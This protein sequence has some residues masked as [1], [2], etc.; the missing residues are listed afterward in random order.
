[1]IT[2][3]WPRLLVV[4]QPVTPTQAGEILLRTDDWW[5]SGNDQA[6]VNDLE[7]TLADYGRPREPDRRDVDGFQEF[8]EFYRLHD[9]WKASLGVLTLHYLQNS[10]IISTW[11]GGPHGWCDWDGT[12]GCSTYNIGKWPSDDEVAEDWQVIAET[13]PFLDLTAHLVDDEG[14]G[15]V[16]GEWRIRDGKVRHN[17]D[18]ADVLIL[19]TEP[20]FTALSDGWERGVSVP[21]LHEALA[22][23]TGGAA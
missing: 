13:F 17:P 4:G 19:P 18:P 2:T 8:R 14:E 5:I 12:I 21:R 7:D 9:E 22:H 3:K 11:I 6:W 23:L 15:A 1:V 16:A 10:R 20:E